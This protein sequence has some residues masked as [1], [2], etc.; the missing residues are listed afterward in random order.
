[1]SDTVKDNT[2]RN[3]VWSMVTIAASSI[4]GFNYLADRQEKAIDKAITPL[5]AELKEYRQKYADLEDLINMN[6]NQLN[7]V[8]VSMAH[9][10]D[11]YNKRHNTTFLKPNDIEIREQKRRR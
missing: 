7:A 2:V 10:L 4:L 3:I 5:I 11:F 9:F 1:M 8:E 6:S